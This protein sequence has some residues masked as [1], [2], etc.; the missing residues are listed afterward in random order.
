MVE[1]QIDQ[2]NAPYSA[3]HEDT[4]SYNS[5][6]HQLSTDPSQSHDPWLYHQDLSRRF[7]GQVTTYENGG[8]VMNLGIDMED[9]KEK[10]R[11]LQETLW[12]DE[13]T[14]ALFVEWSV[15][16]ANTNLFS[17]VSLVLEMSGTG[18]FL[19]HPYIQS[20]RLYRYTANFHLF[21]VAIEIVFMLFIL[22]FI[23]VEVS[24]YRQEGG[25][26]F[27]SIW[28]C[29]EMTTILICLTLVAIYGYRYFIIRRLRL[30]SSW[31]E[32]VSLQLAANVDDAFA[33]LMAFLVIIC[34]V[35]FMHLLRLNPRMYLL[36]TVLDQT[37]MD[38]IAFTVLLT[39][40]V[41]SYTVLF[42]LVF[43]SYLDSYHSYKMAFTNLFNLLLGTFDH[44]ELLEVYPRISP[45]MV[46][47]YL[48]VATY[49]ILNLF[50][51]ALSLAMS[52]VRRNPKYSEDGKLGLLLIEKM[53]SLF[54]IDNR[55]LQKHLNR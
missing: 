18:G 29:L 1:N 13:Q 53:L 51:A 3:E 54:G 46:M 8:Y 30:K 26:Y 4:M 48:C 45:V 49:I 5:S 43:G 42:N 52:D 17:V 55:S 38:L 37:S 32:F 20:V 50:I 10:L 22:Y 19:R 24:K 44:L 12:L 23:Y 16:N 25:K 47:S 28:N 34:T 21:I 40:Y 31:D 6:W 15:Y 2:C 7:W 36:T 41:C 9:G 27:R 33:Y 39:V 35:K 11:M 14:R